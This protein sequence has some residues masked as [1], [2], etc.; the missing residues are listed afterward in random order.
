[1]NTVKFYLNSSEKIPIITG[2]IS[3]FA[4][5]NTPRSA[6]LL[7]HTI[8]CAFWYSPFR[9]R[10]TSLIAQ[11]SNIKV[12]KNETKQ[13]YT[14]SYNIAFA[15]FRM[16]CMI[17]MLLLLCNLLFSLHLKIDYSKVTVRIVYL[18]ANQVCFMKK[19][20]KTNFLNGF[21]PTVNFEC[22]TSMTD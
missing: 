18:L 17:I 6:H 19:K 2:Q 3:A 15:H 16:T 5:T 22:C 14:V 21:F 7:S 8:S 11:A 13:N 10:I 12:G 4:H 1:M 9:T 20:Y